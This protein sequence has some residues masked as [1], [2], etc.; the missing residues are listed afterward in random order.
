MNILGGYA[1]PFRVRDKIPVL[2]NHPQMKATGRG[3]LIRTSA[4]SS[5]RWKLIMWMLYAGNKA[6]VLSDCT[7][8]PVFVFFR[9]PISATLSCPV[10]DLKKGAHNEEQQHFPFLSALR[11]WSRKQWSGT[12]LPALNEATFSWAGS[13][14]L[15]KESLIFWNLWQSPF[16]S[17]T[18]SKLPDVAHDKVFQL[19][20]WMSTAFSELPPPT[21][22]L[23]TQHCGCIAATWK[24]TLA[25]IAP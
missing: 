23:Y 12:L 11:R 22:L 16:L 2:S 7:E 5:R 9:T 4:W 3:K 20:L 15:L 17:N 18:P 13:R 24:N 8:I 25:A 19:F 6:E 1:H 14:S 10:G 21:P